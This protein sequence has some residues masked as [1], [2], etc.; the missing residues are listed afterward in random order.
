MLRKNE[1]KEVVAGLISGIKE[2]KNWSELKRPLNFFDLKGDLEAILASSLGYDF[3]EG[4]LPFLHPG[5]T[6]FIFK[7]KDKI[8]FIGSLNPKLI[9]KLDLK[10]EIK[11]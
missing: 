2:K 6:A 1:E 7:G 8:G 3:N 4:M 9:N 5:K 11:K 10:Q